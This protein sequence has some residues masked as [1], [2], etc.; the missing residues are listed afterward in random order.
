MSSSDKHRARSFSRLF[1]RWA[2]F[3][4][5]ATRCRDARNCNVCFFSSEILPGQPDADS[6]A[7]AALEDAGG[8]AVPEPAEGS[9]AGPSEPASALPTVSTMGM[10]LKGLLPQM[11][12]AVNRP[13][14]RTAESGYGFG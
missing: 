1:L 6:S 13:R 14:R 4:S 11:H 3:N 12:C 9:T 7:I 2:A 8:A 5:L 10:D